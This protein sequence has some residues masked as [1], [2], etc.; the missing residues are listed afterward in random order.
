MNSVG[1]KKELFSRKKK[2]KRKKRVWALGDWAAQWAVPWYNRRVALRAQLQTSWKTDEKSNYKAQ[3]TVLL[4]IWYTPRPLKPTAIPAR[5]A[6][7]FLHPL[8][9]WRISLS[10]PQTG[11]QLCSASRHAESIRPLT[12]PN[13]CAEVAHQRPDRI[14]GHSALC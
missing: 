14:H 7:F 11:Q 4:I 3:M 6:F 2:N 9:H 8:R 1:V 5:P 12:G 13:T 10:L